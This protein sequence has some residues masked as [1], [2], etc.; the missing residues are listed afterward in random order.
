MPSGAPS[1]RYIREARPVYGHPTAGSWVKIG[2]NIYQ[3]LG[4]RS[5][6]WTSIDPVTFTNAGEKTPFFSL[7]MWIGVKHKTLGFD[8]A[9]AAAN[10]IKGILSTASFL[11]I[12]LAFRESEVTHSVTGP[13]LLPFNPPHRP[14]P[15]MPHYEGT[16]ALYFHLSKD[17]NDNRIVP[18]TAARV[19]R[20]PPAYANTGMTCK[21]TSQVREQAVALGNMGHQPGEFVEGEDV[22]VTEKRQ[23][24]QREVEKATKLVDYLNKLHKEVTKRRTNPDKRIVGFVHHA[25]PMVASD[26][27]HGFTYDWAFIKVYNEKIDR[28]TFPG[29]KVYVG[30]NLSPSDFGKLMF[31]QPEY[32]ADY[33]YPYDGL[34]AVGV[35]LDAH[36]EKA[37]FVVKNGLTTGTTISR[38]NRLDPFN[39]VYSDYGIEHTTIETAIL[40][41]DKQRGPFS[42]PG[43]SGAIILDR[44]GSIV[45]LL[46]GGG[47]TTKRQT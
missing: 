34:L 4:S 2:T 24:N 33:E 14:Y 1:Q 44:A 3:F 13:K 12:E 27:P 43:D 38:A 6:K 35:H 18:L 17:D 41:Y 22:V 47:G 29:N 45:A 37:L 26:K 32:Q 15:Q 30:G 28:D 46:T 19:A 16:G 9:V 36:G 42:A 5:V 21:N 23:E 20:P 8:D 11:D 40:P 10:A 39:R 7:L 31:P 25:D